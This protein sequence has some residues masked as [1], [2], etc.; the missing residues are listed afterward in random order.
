MSFP[1][2]QTSEDAARFIRRWFNWFYEHTESL[3]GALGGQLAYLWPAIL[4]ESQIEVSSRSA[5]VQLLKRE[6]IKPTD[7][8]WT[9]LDV[10]G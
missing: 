4:S 2:K 9:Y 5:I 7:Q 1:P 3:E 8:I 6:G 10:V